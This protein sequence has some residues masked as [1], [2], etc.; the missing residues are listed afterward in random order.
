MRKRGSPHSHA[1]S[2]QCQSEAAHVLTWSMAFQNE[3]MPGHLLMQC[4]P[5]FDAWLVLSM[6]GRENTGPC[7]LLHLCYCT[8]L[9][10][11]KL[12]QDNTSLRWYYLTRKMGSGDIANWLTSLA[13]TAGLV[14]T[15]ITSCTTYEKLLTFEHVSCSYRC[16]G[17][18][19]VRQGQIV[20]VQL[21]VGSLGGCKDHS[22]ITR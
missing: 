13:D 17:E 9:R 6:P 18:E 10:Y 8:G 21:I 14:Q 12:Q 20:H 5:T 22:C 7:T 1:E 15:T 19:A 4:P 16:S 3:Q 2:R 11:L